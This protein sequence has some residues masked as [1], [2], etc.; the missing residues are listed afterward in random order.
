MIRC[1][2]RET[3]PPSSEYESAEKLFVL[4]ERGFSHA[5]KPM[6]SNGL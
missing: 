6:E 4:K 1:E 2:H 5:V 3:S